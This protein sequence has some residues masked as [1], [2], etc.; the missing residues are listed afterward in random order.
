MFARAHALGIGICWHDEALSRKSIP[1][2]LSHLPKPWR[3]NAM[4]KLGDRVTLRGERR[5][6]VVRCEKGGK[7]GLRPPRLPESAGLVQNSTSIVKIPDAECEW[8]LERIVRLSASRA[9]R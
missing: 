4:Y 6:F 2:T 8:W 9:R 7:G 5:V 3:P 1:M